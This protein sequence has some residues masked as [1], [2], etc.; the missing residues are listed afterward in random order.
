MK[1]RD[2][3]GI[4]EEQAHAGR[5]YCTPINSNWSTHM[6]TFLNITDRPWQIIDPD[7]REI[8]TLC[9]EQSEM[10]QKEMLLYRCQMMR[11]SHM[12][13][14]VRL[15]FSALTST[16]AV[17]VTSYPARG[18]DTRPIY[19]WEKVCV[20]VIWSHDAT[21]LTAMKWQS[22]PAVEEMTNRAAMTG[23]P[24]NILNNV[25]AARN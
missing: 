4:L 21:P 6:H 3:A 15:Q 23:K 2:T 8:Q 18:T 20:V 24:R 10:L 14:A 11:S 25:K 7:T 5:K 16:M 17:K 22:N 1:M 12:Q 9:V 19:F 13:S